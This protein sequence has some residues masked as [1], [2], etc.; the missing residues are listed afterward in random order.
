MHDVAVAV[1]VFLSQGVH[2]DIG[3]HNGV[4]SP[5]IPTDV[6]NRLHG[7]H[8]VVGWSRVFGTVLAR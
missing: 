3:P 5:T 7:N 2:F 4:L 8:S 6:T 1:E